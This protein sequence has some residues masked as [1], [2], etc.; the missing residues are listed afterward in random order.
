MCDGEIL[1]ANVYDN[2]TMKIKLVIK[3]VKLSKI[4]YHSIDKRLFLSP[5]PRKEIGNIGRSNDLKITLILRQFLR[6]GTY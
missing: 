3:N 2:L 4:K 5:L 6:H 1:N